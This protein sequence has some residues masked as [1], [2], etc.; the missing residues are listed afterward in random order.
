MEW[1]L[2]LEETSTF[3]I[4]TTEKNIVPVLTGESIKLDSL[5]QCLEVF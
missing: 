1:D 3:I 4:P 2:L 5:P